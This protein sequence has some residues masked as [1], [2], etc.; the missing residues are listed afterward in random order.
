[1]DTELK[2]APAIEATAL[3]TPSA[4]RGANDGSERC[5]IPETAGRRITRW[6]V[7]VVLRAGVAGATL[8]GGTWSY[9]TS[10]E[11]PH[12]VP[13]GSSHGHRK[14]PPGATSEPYALPA[15]AA[16]AVDPPAA[17]P[18]RRTVA[19]K[20][21][22]WPAG[23]VT[24]ERRYLTVLFCDLVDSTGIASRLDPEE[25]RDLVGA[26]FESASAAVTGLGG[27][28]AKRLGDG[29]MAF[30]GYP[31]AHENDAERAARAALAI[32][33]AIAALNRPNADTARPMLVS[34]IGIGTGPVVVDAAGEIFGDAPNVASRVQALA[35]PGGIMITAQVQRQI[36][37]LFVA[38]DSGT[39]ALKG[40]PEP[41]ALFRLVRASGGGRRSGMRQLT[42][43]VGREEETALVMRRWERAR[44]GDGQLVLIVG[45]PGVGKSRL[46]EEFRGRLR[47]TSHTWLE[48]S[49]SQLLQNTP[50]HP[51]AEWGRQVFGGADVSAERRLANLK[52]T[53]AQMKLDPAENAPLLAPL[54]DIPLLPERAPDLAPD[55]WRRRQL[56]AITEA[57]TAGARIQ[58]VVLAIEDLHWADPTTLDVLKG[59]AERGG[60]APLF[61]VA[62]TRP[63][64]RP[65]W[66]MRSHH[67]TVALAPLDRAQVRDM[68]AALTARHALPSELADKVAERTGGVPLFVEEVTRL[69]LE[70]GDKAGIPPSLQQ[71]LMARLDRLG[72]ARE[73]AQVGSVIGRGFSYGLL[74]ALTGMADTVLQAAL[75]RLEDADILLVQG[76]PPDADYHF[77]HALIQDAAY[78]NLL[79][80]RRQ[81]LHRGVAGILRDRFP[82][83]AAAEPEVLAHHFT[84]AGLTDAAVEWWGKA[85]EEALRRSAFQEAI[86]HLGKAIEIA[87]KI[88]DGGSAAATASASPSQRLKLQTDL[89]KA[90]MF[91]RGF[92][93][94]E[95]KA[96][97]IRARELA[98]A[99]DNPAERFNIYYG[100]WVSNA[101]RGELELAREIAETLLRE[102]E[103]G[104]QTTESGVSRGLMGFTCLWQGDFIE[105]QANLVEALNCY[106]PERDREAAFRFGLDIGATVRI[107]L[108]LTKRLL[109]DVGPARALIEGGIAQAIETDHVPTLVNC[110]FWKSHFEIVCGDAAAARRD[111]G[112]L[113]KLSQDNALALFATS[114]ALVSGWASA[115]LGGGETGAT[116]L[117]QGL[118]AF[119]D[120]GTKLSV[121][122][123][124]GLVAEIEA[125]GDAVE[126]LTRIDEALALA[127]ETGEH[128]SDAFLYRLRG[129]ILLKRDPANTMPAEEAFMTAIAIARQQKARSFELRAALG[130]GRLYDSTGRAVDA[131]AVLAPALEGFSPTP[132]FPEIEEAQALLAGLSE[133]QDVKDAVASRQR[134]LKLQTS[135]GRALMY[136]RGFGAEES[137]A[138]FTQARELATAID[139]PTERFNIYYGLWI[140]N[141]MRG[142]LRLAR[143]IAETFLREA[144]RESR[145]M[146]CSVGHRLV[147]FICL[148]LGDLVDAQSNFLEALSI[149]DPERDCEA[150]FRFGYDIGAIAR[151]FLALA[152]WLLGE[153]GPTRAIL[154]EAVAN[155]TGTGHVPTRVTT[156]LWKAHFEMVRGDA[157]SA[158]RDA[159]IVVK[160]SQENALTLYEAMGAV[161]SAWSRARVDSSGTGATKLRQELATFIDQGNKLTVPFYQGLLAEIEAQD[162][163]VGA[164]I[165]IDE[166]LALAR[167]TGEHWSDAFLHRL[168]GE[169]LLKRD[170]ADTMP[171][172]EAYL[173]AIAV[174]Q[175]QKARSFALRAALGL[176]Q[177]YNSTGH[178]V[179]AHAVLAP[180]LE[181]FAPTPELPEIAQAQSLLV[182]LAS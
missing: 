122:F 31:A 40:L 89:G 94:E 32:Q 115:R 6:L 10:A 12:P 112:I 95:T 97:F 166:G 175:E 104:V 37:G 76:L 148:W 134:R 147:G 86:S 149:Y 140:G 26:Y 123:F 49:C 143:D 98:A 58:P 59:I 56:A 180:A 8:H 156:Y 131:H 181:G 84:Q 69:L 150:R 55:E 169:I 19:G 162:D 14:K 176:A 25:W 1:L 127:R 172:E 13:G 117:R 126:A 114:G 139:N 52:S 160:L 34:R 4:A 116:E 179:D 68:M 125:Q 9:P 44:Q 170:P 158:R 151:V 91:S 7:D 85:G 83:I 128:W 92:G 67:A 111:A 54:L 17:L 119:T 103:S 159:E 133:T 45:E 43:L 42:R 93:T 50:L 154:E 152:K 82:D 71:S 138:A 78:E 129:E 120:L 135:L 73:V 100:L 22:P 130:L 90:L 11:G 146:E 173:T 144:E 46:I 47:D 2:T 77:K 48:W 20:P 87:D 171:A 75:E 108:A 145:V 161:E 23:D 35:E 96:A 29:L 132:E 167:E 72:P 101:T 63:E 153:V 136:S 142:E 163:A 61:I 51:I 39:H 105:A 88:G 15:E 106:D 118:A 141:L 36:A 102:A 16:S 5:P 80:T 124:Q 70:R 74:R 60:L 18:E 57:V 178:A 165:R 79:R 28:V 121:P 62:T 33:R 110:Y 24:G 66:G 107:F 137:K 53:L 27:T 109:G 3:S 99:I 65:P 30:F 177:L 155:A 168:R 38:E 64:F 174:A 113:V 182:A 157:A 41:V 21:G 164:L 81:V